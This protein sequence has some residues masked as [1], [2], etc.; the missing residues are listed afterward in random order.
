MDKKKIAD[1]VLEVVGH[2]EIKRL[3]N[4]MALI[5]EPQGNRRIDV[6]CY[7]LFAYILIEEKQRSKDFLYREI[8]RITVGPIY[9]HRI[10]SSIKKQ[11]LEDDKMVKKF[12]KL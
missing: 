2:W 6:R 7:G 12:L 9:T 10:N 11:E 3:T 5:T 4:S 1:F 8:A